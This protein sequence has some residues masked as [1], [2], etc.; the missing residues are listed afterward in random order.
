MKPQLAVA[1][2][3]PSNSL[4]TVMNGSAKGTTYQVIGSKV[5]LGRGPD[6]DIVITDDPKCSRN[7]AELRLGLNG[8]EIHDI[9]EQNS[10]VV[11]GKEC[12]RALLTTQ[13]LFIL[14]N[15]QFQFSMKAL[16]L[17][18]TPG[19]FSSHRASPALNGMTATRPFPRTQPAPK[20]QP[21]RSPFSKWIVGFVVL[22]MVWIFFP[23]STKVKDK[24][25]LNDD[26]VSEEIKIAQ[27]IKEEGEQRSRQFAGANEMAYKQAQESFVAGFRD[28]KK[29]QFERAL[30]SFQACVSLFPQ[31]L[32]CNRY[33]KL[34]Q[35]RFDELIQYH[36]VLGRKYRDQNQFEACRSAF[37]NVM[38]MLGDQTNKRYQE[39]KANYEA[40]DA[41]TEGR[42]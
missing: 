2:Y 36:V 21:T 34:T 10:M 5:T 9:T 20:I 31:H 40:C 26:H 41:R 4:L 12:K 39:A 14:G 1:S 25:V 22:F 3:S 30:A 7:H 19:H 8:Y 13:S 42:F 23:K 24:K 11:D 28:Y 29:G 38:V 32:L 33:L 27:K 37:R 16:A 6:N 17:P 15:T 35:R 18:E